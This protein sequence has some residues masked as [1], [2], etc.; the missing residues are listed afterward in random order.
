[1]AETVCAASRADCESRCG[2]ALIPIEDQ[3]VQEAKTAGFVVER[4]DMDGEDVAYVALC[5]R[6][7][8][9]IGVAERVS[10]FTGGH[11]DAKEIGERVA[12]AQSMQDYAD[13]RAITDALGN[14]NRN[15]GE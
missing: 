1:M 5:V 13:H 4:D 12:S 3:A 2:I 10:S 15:E 11:V 14:K 6:S 7:L 8:Q 9:G